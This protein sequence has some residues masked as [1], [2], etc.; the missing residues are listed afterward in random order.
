MNPQPNF[1][2]NPNIT[3]VFNKDG[4]PNSKRIGVNKF[5]NYNIY[6]TLINLN[7]FHFMI[8][9][10][11]LFIIINSF[12]AT[13]LFF[14]PQF[15]SLGVSDEVT[16]SH[17]WK[18]FFLSTQTMTTVG[19]DQGGFISNIICSIEALVGFLFF[20]L[21]TG[22][23]YG[24]FSR[25]NAKLFFSKNIIVNTSDNNITYNIR[26]AN[27]KLSQLIE[28]KAQLIIALDNKINGKIE[29]K[30]HYVNLLNESIAFL[31]S[32][33]VISHVVD[34]NSPLYN[35]HL[36]DLKNKNLEIIILIKAIDDTYATEVHT[37]TSYHCD[38]VIW[39]ADFIPITEIKNDSLI[40]YIRNLDNY[41]YLN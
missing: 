5:A 24:R 18:L 8:F 17:W 6:H 4:T 39:G 16:F 32:S 29:R 26:V 15:V 31:D 2:Q 23:L 22:L 36:N 35:L 27:A 1:N 19:Y 40:T 41:K 20:A 11:G 34:R 38:N 3:K 28:V 21:I 30:F 13:I 14:L 12:F 7:T 9:V 10:F 25:P 37:R 33:W